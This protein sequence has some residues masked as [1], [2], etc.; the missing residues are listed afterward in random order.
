[1]NR[2]DAGRTVGACRAVGGQELENAQLPVAHF[3]EKD[4]ERDGRAVKEGTRTPLAEDWVVK[5]RGGI[6]THS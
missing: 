4:R 5:E 1:M 3:E 2:N 6:R